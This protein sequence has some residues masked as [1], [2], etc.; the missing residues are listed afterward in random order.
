MKSFRTGAWRAVLP[1]LALVALSAC[2]P[3]DPQNIFDPRSD[4]T[5]MIADLFWQIIWWAVGVF[6]VVELA[7]V[8]AIFRFRR[9]AGQ[10][11]PPQI[12][13]NTRLEIAWTIAPALVLAS[14]AV[15]TVQIIFKTYEVPS[16]PDVLTIDVIGRQYWWEY[17]YP[18]TNVVTATDLH[19]PVN[20][21][22][23]LRITGADVIHSY[24]IPKLGAKRDAI[25]GHINTIWFK[26][27]QVGVYEGQCAEFCGLQHANMRLRVFVDDQATFEQWLRANSQPAREPTTPEQ[28][29]GKE[30]VVRGTCAG[31]HAIDGTDAKGKVGPNLT[32][33]ASRSRIAAILPNTTENLDRWLANPDEVKP[34]NLMAAVRVL[35]PQDRQAIIA[36]L[37]S[38]Q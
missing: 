30:L 6:I 31:C 38:L 10:G 26:A 34:G 23:V 20:R 21:T 22:V 13:G 2:S 29:R 37:Q 3:T 5:R 35:N 16:G 33:F 4:F 15:P 24:W 17:R 18:G 7:L 19:V 8:Y 11:L 14:I 36:Y 32:H 12:H 27:E 28:Q 9:R 1:F 25:P